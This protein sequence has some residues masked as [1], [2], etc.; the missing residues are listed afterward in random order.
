M[1]DSLRLCRCGHPFYRHRGGQCQ[2]S[3]DEICDCAGFIQR[4]QA[5]PVTGRDGRTITLTVEEFR[6]QR[7]S[8]WRTG[9]PKRTK[10]KANPNTRDRWWE[11]N[12][13]LVGDTADLDLAVLVAVADAD[14]PVEQ[15]RTLATE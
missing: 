13:Q 3:R 14:D 7:G 2:P 5:I 6:A 12:G 10:P 9:P 1:T 15:C 8:P 4:Q 11:R